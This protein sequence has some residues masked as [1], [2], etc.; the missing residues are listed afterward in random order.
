[1]E[2]EQLR[3]KLSLYIKEKF[4]D[5]FP[6]NSIIDITKNTL[7]PGVESS[8]Y[9]F[10]IE[11]SNLKAHK[12]R[13]DLVLK[14][15]DGI[16]SKSI[17]DSD[18]SVEIEFHVLKFLSLNKISTPFPYAF[19]YKSNKFFKNSLV[20]MDFIPGIPFPEIYNKL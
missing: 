10:T 16:N 8:I 19:E 14:I 13:K 20:I 4:S 12:K 11:F 17:F 3:I 9:Y 7:N 2:L 1:M 15:Y 6:N 18:H 5:I